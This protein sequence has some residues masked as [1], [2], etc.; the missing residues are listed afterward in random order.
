MQKKNPK[1]EG[2]DGAKFRFLQSSLLDCCYFKYCS[3]MLSSFLF[4]CHNS[5]SVTSPWVWMEWNTKMALY[6]TFTTVPNELYGINSWV[7]LRAWRAVPPTPRKPGWRANGG[8]GCFCFRKF[9]LPDAHLEECRFLN[10]QA[11]PDARILFSYVTST[12]DEILYR[13]NKVPAS[14]KL[15]RSGG[16]KGANGRHPFGNWQLPQGDNSSEVS[17]HEDG[18]SLLGH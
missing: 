11:I 5:S 12:R 17:S 7:C 13:I 3:V 9:F 1:K 4:L 18:F 10:F 14:R 8:Y 16:W 6:K 15:H 2:K